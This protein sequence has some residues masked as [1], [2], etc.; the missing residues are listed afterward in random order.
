MR[1]HTWRW[2]ADDRTLPRDLRGV[3]F[4]DRSLLEALPAVGDEEPVELPLSGSYRFL[5]AIVAVVVIGG[6]MALT[7]WFVLGPHIAE[8]LAR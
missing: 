6:A 1:D 2:S 3:A 7:G 8:A 4:G 5:R